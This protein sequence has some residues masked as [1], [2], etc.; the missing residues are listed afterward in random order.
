MKQDLSDMMKAKLEMLINNGSALELDVIED[1]AVFLRKKKILQN[2]EVDVLKGTATVQL[3]HVKKASNEEEHVQYLCHYKYLHKDQDSI[4]L[5]EKVEDRTAVFIQ[6]EIVRDFKIEHPKTE[7]FDEKPAAGHD[8]APFYYDRLAAVQYAE[9]WWNSHNPKFKNFDVNCTNYVSQCL[10]A[11]GAR[12]RGYPGRSSGWW[13][14]NNSW[15]YSWTVA[16]SLTL[17]LGNS[18][19]GLRATSVGAPEALMPGDVICYDFQGD[20][21]FDHTTIVVAKDQAN[22]PLVNANTY[23]SRMRYWDYEDSTAYT[24]NIKY[25]FFHIEDDSSPKK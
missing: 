7:K 14:Q 3:T 24:P 16:H 13:M 19:T 6:G 20:G 25:K 10:H 23:N 12:M 1:R 5:E 9:R 2:R 22:M 17:F 15:S 18:K 11:G 8:R 4:Y 21:R